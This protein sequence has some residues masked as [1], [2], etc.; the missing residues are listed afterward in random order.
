MKR[1]YITSILVLV[2]TLFVSF[3]MKSQNTIVAN[4]DAFY[5]TNPDIT[6]PGISPV[7]FNDQI[8][9]APINFNQVNITLLNSPTPLIT[10]DI[11]GSV[12]VNSQT[13]NGVYVLQYQ[14]CIRTDPTNCATAFVT[15][16]VDY[17]RTPTP[18]IDAVIQPTCEV[19][20]GTVNLSGLPSIASWTIT[21]VQMNGPAI[22]LTGIG[23]TFSL[24]NLFPGSYTLSVYED[25]LLGNC[26]GS[27]NINITIDDFFE[28]STTMT[29]TY[30]DYNNDGFTNLGDLITYQFGISNS[31]C[32]TQQISITSETVSIIG[33]PITV[34]PNDSNNT[35]IGTYTLTQNDIN[36]GVVY[37]SAMISGN[38][39][40][41]L[42]ASNTS[43]NLSDGIKLFAFLDYNSN[44]VQDNSEQYFNFGEFHYELNNNGTINNITTNNGEH[45]IYESNPLNSYHVS[46]TINDNFAAYYTVSPAS[47]S[48]ISIANGSGITPYSFAITT[49]PYV[50]AACHISNYSAP[51]RPGFV[52]QNYLSYTNQGNQAIA[53]GTVTFVKDP[54]LT[55]T[56]ASESGIVVNA[57]GFTF[58][59]VNLLP[60]QTRYIAVN[61]QVPTIPTVTLGQQVTN[62][63][64]ISIP[65]NDAN[66]ANNTSSLTQTIVGSY[67]PN[68]KSE[69]HGNN[70]VFS[71]FSIDDYLTYTIRFENT[72]TANAV[73][74]KV[75]DLL[76]TQL[77]ENTVR[78][79]SASHPYVLERINNSLT[80]K[81]DGIDLPPSIEGDEVTGHGYIVF[82]VKPKTGFALGDI[83]PNTADIYFDFN[84]AIVTNTWTTEFVPFLGINAF[85]PDT[86]EYYPNPTSDMVTF[87]LKNTSTTID[88]I[89]V[90]DIL[91]KTLLSKT[92][93]LSEA[94]I[95]LSSL[96]KGMYLVKV[97]AAGKEKTVKITKN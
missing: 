54:L 63:C 43:L 36:T 78:T 52:Y 93:N 64:S 41:G 88:T 70:V 92:V 47:Y 67:D 28:V 56:N 87:N 69:S 5:I 48:N 86:F 7:T 95:D 68:D 26:F 22:S 84:P 13:P 40:I 80:W 32:S 82:Q 15:V 90:M 33:S 49:I 94:S 72:G 10:L 74:V 59:F 16:T 42:I 14:V 83:I 12:V 91:G 60:G 75:D 62:T 89:E 58:D 77:D 66:T 19:Q 3:S 37:N 23:E 53:S 65:N 97:R 79:I 57:N 9:G 29:D 2:F 24:Q 39:F 96:S 71:T 55:I 17:C 1:N 30:V 21:L 46:F 50:D 35:I 4:D 76:N 31:E 18:I 85:A 6:P 8:N 44:G 51:P 27:I 34:L 25:I 20:S 73:N 61:M 81:F 11:E 38:D 45:Y